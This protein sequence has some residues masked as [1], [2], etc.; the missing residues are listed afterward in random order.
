MRKWLVFSCCVLAVVLPAGIIAQPARQGQPAKQGW[1]IDLAGKWRFATDPADKGIKEEWWNNT[2]PDWIRLPGSMTTNNKGDEISMQ[3]PWMGEIVDSSWYTSP[4]YAR[5]RRPG[6]IKVP[7][8]LQPVKYYK[9]AAW[10]QK[11]VTIPAGWKDR[12]IELTLERC[13]WETMVWVDGKYAG[14][15]NSLGTPHVYVLPDR[16]S[17]G[18][19]RV[20]VRVDNRIKEFNPGPNSHSISDH[21]QGNWNGL[22]GRLS[23]DARP[24]V[25]LEDV[26]LYPDL[27]NHRVLARIRIGNFSR[28]TVRTVVRLQAEGQQ[29]ISANAGEEELLPVEAKVEIGPDSSYLEISYPMGNHPLL[30]DEFHPN[31]YQMQISLGTSD[32]E[33]DVKRIQFGM[34]EFTGSGTQFSINGRLTFLRG[35]LECAI[36]PMTGY[37]PTDRGSWMHILSV[38]RSY[39]LNHIRFH[40]WCPPEAAFDA[41]D[42]LGFYLHVEMGSWANG[43]STVGDSSGIDRYLYEESN[44]IVSAYGNHPSFCMMA[45]GNEPAGK[46]LVS[47]LT[48]FVN[49]WKKKDSRRLYTTAAG[50][51]VIPDN[52]YNSSPDP[53]IQQWGDGLNSVINRLPPAT[54]FDWS[55]IIAKWRHPTVSHEI[56]QWCAYPDLKEIDKYTGAL[57]AKNFEIFRAKLSENGLGH[58]SDS[59]LLASGKLQALCYKA[60]IEAALRTPGFGGFQLLSLYDFPGQGSALVGVLNAFWQDKGYIHA[61]QFSRFCGPIVPLARF[62]KLVYTNDEV[63][64]VPLELANFGEA[65]L[66]D[67]EITWEIRDDHGWLFFH[68]LLQARNIPLGNGIQLGQIRTSLSRVQKASK[69]TVRVTVAGH[70]NSWEIF[71]YPKVVP[72]IHHIL[73]TQKID[74]AAI[75]ELNKGGKVLLTLKKGTL[76]PAFGGNIKIGFSSIFWNSTWTGGQPPAT[77]GILCDPKHPAFKNFPTE[78]YSN[79]EWWDAM[80]HSNAIKLDSI[81]IGLTPIVRVIDD[82]VTANPLGLIFECKAGKGQLLVSGIDLLTQQDS[83]P[84]ARQLLFSLLSYMKGEAFRPSAKVD[85]AKIVGLYQEN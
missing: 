70:L 18:P 49:Y 68:G 17:P 20:T 72:A 43:G 52:D 6:H 63:L 21:T 5:Y 53:R 78:Y 32:G 54:D 3:T 14:M 84:E 10:Y 67:Q 24:S 13:H 31:L 66:K 28:K 75:A 9:G 46:H 80:S 69:L 60:D 27:P 51:P 73:V 7:F 83:R 76:K 47:F 41:A 57:K 23:L 29:A 1:G 34:R 55:N 44:R 2:I 19:H 22:V 37:P 40:S 30:W 58:F 62:S 48:G 50:W 71:V 79:Y 38:A 36:F 35:T 8:W 82:W 61:G 85:L 74:P 77:L 64:D 26:Q 33:R 15:N 12:F 59:F 65:E 16:L 42:R 4:E 39:G 56:G 81:A 11:M 25:H 45:Y